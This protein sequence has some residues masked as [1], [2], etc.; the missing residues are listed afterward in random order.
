MLKAMQ[1]MDEEATIKYFARQFNTHETSLP[2]FELFKLN[3]SKLQG[4]LSAFLIT[5]EGSCQP[6]CQFIL[7]PNGTPRQNCWNLFR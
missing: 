2:S 3:G 6:P 4:K 7:F 5:L 1:R